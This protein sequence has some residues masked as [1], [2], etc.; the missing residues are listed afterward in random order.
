ML[1]FGA[2]VVVL[3]LSTSVDGGGVFLIKN[4]SF[5]DVLLREFGLLEIYLL[6]GNCVYFNGNFNAGLIQIKKIEN[7]RQIQ[8]N[9]NSYGKLSHYVISGRRVT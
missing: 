7:V 9:S 3:Q 2:K 5:D 4:S 8:V 1:F 6:C